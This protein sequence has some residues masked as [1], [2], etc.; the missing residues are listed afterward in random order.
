MV[1]TRHLKI[2]ASMCCLLIMYHILK[3]V[4]QLGK[5]WECPVLVIA[6]YHRLVLY[7][8][9]LET[10]KLVIRKITIY[11]HMEYITGLHPNKAFRKYQLMMIISHNGYATLFP[12]Q[13]L[14]KH[15]RILKGDSCMQEIKSILFQ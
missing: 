13:A 14:L 11:E 12:K 2:N 8:I 6:S 3:S 9:S 5:V 4:V 7:V 1:Y 15:I 10:M